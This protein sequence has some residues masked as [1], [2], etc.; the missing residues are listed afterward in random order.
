MKSDEIMAKYIYLRIVHK[1]K[2]KR[3]N[4]QCGID[5]NKYLALYAQ[6]KQG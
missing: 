5:N 4:C 6:M 2:W 1:N 3:H